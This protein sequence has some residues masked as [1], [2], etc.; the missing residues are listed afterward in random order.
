[1]KRQMER[2][3]EYKAAGEDLMVLVFRQ[4]PILWY[5][6]GKFCL[7][8]IAN[9]SPLN[10]QDDWQWFL[11]GKKCNGRYEGPYTWIS[12]EIEKK[13]KNFRVF[14]RIHG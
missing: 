5:L 6:L 1:M 2:E 13:K 10:R 9:F 7:L 12:I 14:N 3:I 11:L 4:E 8:S